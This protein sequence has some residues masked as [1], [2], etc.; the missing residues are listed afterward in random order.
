MMIRLIV[1]GRRHRKGPLSLILRSLR[2]RTIKMMRMVMKRKWRI[3]AMKEILK[4]LIRLPNNGL[5]K[6]GP[7]KMIDLCTVI[8][9]L[10]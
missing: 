8:Q 10:F 6:S 9:I 1:G 4:M 3:L 7:P 5:R 2:M